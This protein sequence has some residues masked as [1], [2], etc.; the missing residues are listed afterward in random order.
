M[1]LK[2]FTVSSN[3]IPIE[4]QK[5]FFFFK[6]FLRYFFYDFLLLDPLPPYLKPPAPPIIVLYRKSGKNRIS[7]ADRQKRTSDS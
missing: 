3:A 5:R 7:D 6:F 2:G 4:K 1:V